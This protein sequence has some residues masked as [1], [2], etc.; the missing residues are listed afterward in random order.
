MLIAALNVCVCWGR[1]RRGGGRPGGVVGAQVGFDGIIDQILR[2]LRVAELRPHVRVVHLH[3]PA[4][5]TLLQPDVITKMG[6]GLCA[7]VFA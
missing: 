1:G 2:Q 3:R 6:S 5:A 7:V 4:P